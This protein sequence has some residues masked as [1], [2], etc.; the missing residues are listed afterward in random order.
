MVAHKLPHQAKTISSS[1]LLLVCK[2]GFPSFRADVHQA[3]RFQ[4]TQICC[5][6]RHVSQQAAPYPGKRAYVFE[7]IIRRMHDVGYVRT[8]P[9]GFR[10]VFF[11]FNFNC[12]VEK[13]RISSG[14]CCWK[15][16]QF[17]KTVFWK[18]NISWASEC[19][20]T[21]GPTAQ[22][23]LVSN[24]QPWQH[25]HLCRPENIFLSQTSTFWIF[26]IHGNTRNYSEPKTFS[27]AKPAHFGFSSSNFTVQDHI[28][29]TPGDALSTLLSIYLNYFIVPKMKCMETRSEG[30]TLHL[31]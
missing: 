29:S 21:L 2:L 13:I 6:F 17:A 12:A 10:V 24:Y 18:E 7:I 22:A 31:N 14:F 3:V 15:F 28:P 11:F 25:A 8:L 30:F 1:F 23:T 27:W 19:V 4:S 5:H 9:L 26:F 20:H 16:K